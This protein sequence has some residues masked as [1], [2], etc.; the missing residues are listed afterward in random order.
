M[1]NIDRH[2]EDCIVES[3]KAFPVVYIA[4]P[5][6]SGKTTLVQRIAATRHKARYITFDDIQ[7]RS[8]AQRDPDAFLRSLDGATV[9]DEIQLAPELYRP[10]KIIVD[11]NRAH[12]DA[13][14]GKFLLTGSASIMALPNLSDAL[15]GRMALHTLLPLSTNEVQ[16]T[17]NNFI[18]QAFL[19]EWKFA[20]LPNENITAMMIQASFPELLTLKNHSLRYE[21]C[22]SYINTILQR[23]IRALMEV[24]KLEALPDMLRL[25]ASRT[26]GLLNESSLSD[27]IQINHLTCKKYRLLLEG[28]FL[29]RTV[30]AWS[31]NLGK[32]LIKAPKV[33]IN[34]INIIAYLL[35]IDLNDL[36][37]QNPKLFGHIL[38]NFVAVE[39]SKQLT[40]SETHAT[41]Y[42]YRTSSKQEVDFILEG[43]QNHV[44]G[45]EVK[46]NSKVSARDFRHLEVLKIDL[47]KKFLRGFVM[48]N[49]NDIVPFGENMWAIPVATLWQSLD[50]NA[51]TIR[52]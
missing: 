12:A 17:A 40:F 45:I 24:E 38:E 33:Y 39:L 14:R 43:P 41:L 32:R 26:G 42:H 16:N 44:V 13:G 34:D 6:Q 37:H 51:S 19:N 4:G 2:L 48:Y 35:N 50:L 49:G 1:G 52:H 47:G 25:L 28:L 5:R 3:L 20:Q 30:P 22:N 29:T 9:L 21:W 7:M 36:P 27:D 46:S 15:V 18:E 31:N 8:A 11:E 23:D 10:L